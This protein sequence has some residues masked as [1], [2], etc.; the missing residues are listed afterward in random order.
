MSK[1]LTEQGVPS[2][3]IMLEELSKDTIGNIYFCGK[4]FNNYLTCSSEINIYTHEFHAPR[5][6]IIYNRLWEYN[7]IKKSK[8]EHS[9][10]YT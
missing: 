6:S 5:V 8:N 1:W 7:W 10:R 2:N 4:L 3:I 9:R